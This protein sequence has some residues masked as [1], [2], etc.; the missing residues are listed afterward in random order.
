[1]ARGKRDTQVEPQATRGEQKNEAQAKKG[2]WSARSFGRTCAI[3]AG[4]IVVWQLASWAVGNPILFAGPLETAQA[5]VGLLPD[6]HFWQIVLSSAVHILVGFA[7]AFV[8]GLVLAGLSSTHAF[9]RHALAPL[10]Q[11]IKATPLVCF[12]VL[13][14]LWVGS[15]RVSSYA[16]FLVGFP[17][18][19]F[20][21]LQGFDADDGG[22]QEA[23][24]VMGVG[25]VR[26]ALAV[27]WPKA[28]PYVLAAC[29]N[30]CGM[31]WKAGVAAE[32]IGTPPNTI[33]ERIYQSRL[34]LE[35]QDLFAWTIV[36]ILLSY[37][38][39]RA[40]LA[41]LCRSGRATQALG[42]RCGWPPAS[43]VR[44]AQEPHAKPASLELRDVT[45]D[46][47]QGPVLAHV[48]HAFAP[49]SLTCLDDASGRGKTC[50]LRMLAGVLAP[51][52]GTVRT[53]GRAG[54][55]FQETRLVDQLS[56]VDNVRLVAGRWMTE[57][58]VRQQLVQLLPSDV[59]DRPV[60]ELSGGQRRRVEVVRA[61]CVHAGVVLMD[62]PFSSLDDVSRSRTIAYVREHLRG[63]TL[64]MSSHQA[65]DARQMGATPLRIAG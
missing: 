5:L 1:M 39:E 57:E 47:G 53:A 28:L 40:F 18:I 21:A 52:A 44:D 55:V 32:L 10:V 19:Y 8:L 41:L 45:L 37:A 38:F 26:R 11:T 16:V 64:V 13:L 65:D 4:W 15:R 14:L 12:V 22:V 36:V 27:T 23:L 2:S 6:V 20:A 34:L 54:M 42:A 62:E 9:V 3:A 17:A 25:G 7:L 60:A 61:L 35:T 59:V 58:Q 48:N 33:G 30:A 56:A 24:R 31:S 49:G 43:Q 29:R 50:C 46:F 63:R 51:S